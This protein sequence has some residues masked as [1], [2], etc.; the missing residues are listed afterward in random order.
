MNIESIK[1]S[2]TYNHVHLLITLSLLVSLIWVYYGSDVIKLLPAESTVAYVA[3]CDTLECLV[4]ERTDVI[5]NRDQWLYWE[6][7][8]TI[9]MDS[10]GQEVV[11][12]M[13]E[14][15]IQR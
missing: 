9:A 12:M 6:Q 2:W 10:V 1:E 15:I 3:P 11:Q 7:A 4:Q 8:R 5:F 13:Y 14:P